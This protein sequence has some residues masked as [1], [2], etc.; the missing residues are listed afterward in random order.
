[1]CRSQPKKPDEDADCGY[2]RQQRE[3]MA[4][5]GTKAEQ[6]TVVQRGFNPD[7]PIEKPPLAVDGR[8]STPMENPVL[9]QKVGDTA[10]DGQNTENEVSAKRY[11]A[12]FRDLRCLR[13][14]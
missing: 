11:G 8:H 10:P 12:Q 6:R 3:D 2:H 14:C 7:I 13:V 4:I 5:P 9:G 1:M